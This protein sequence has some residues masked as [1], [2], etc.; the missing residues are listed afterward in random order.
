MVS[1][2]LQLLLVLFLQLI[3]QYQA[4]KQQAPEAIQDRNYA[5]QILAAA[6]QAF[7]EEKPN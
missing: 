3:F 7:E 4:L 5:L 1:A 6:K 2:T